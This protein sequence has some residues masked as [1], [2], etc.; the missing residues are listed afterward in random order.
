LPP[1]RLLALALLATSCR[2]PAPPDAIDPALASRVP[3]NAIAL[4]G[5]DLDQLRARWAKL[6]AFL[7]PFR[8]AHSLLIASTG[9]EFLTITRGDDIA[10]LGP[11]G[12]IAAANAPHPPAAILATAGP[13]VAHH[14]IWIAIRGGTPL[15]LEGNFANA[16]NLVTVAETIVLTATLRDAPLDTLDLDLT[17]R[18]PTPAA[19]I[20]FEQRL[21][22]L[23]T[24]TSAG[25]ARRPE[26]AAL[27]RAIQLR[28]DDRTVR[29]TVSASPASIQLLVEP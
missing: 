18:C 10:L 5:I 15:P 4:A 19:A 14:P 1:L 17:A 23:I 25:N 7:E 8:G 3:P 11:P 2:A 28:R 24:L 12:L 6:P 22:A 21:R 29:A 13:A 20:Q 16:N 9:A 27:L 26:I